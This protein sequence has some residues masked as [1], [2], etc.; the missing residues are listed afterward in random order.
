A[1]G[2]L[3]NAGANRIVDL[4]FDGKPIDRNQKFVV[5]TNNYRAGGGGNFPDINASKI[6][7]EAPDTNRDVIVRY[8]VSEGT[9]NPSA[10]DNWSFAPLP[11]ASAVFETGPR[12]K[13]FIAQVKSLKIEP[14]G[15]GE[16][17]FAKYRILL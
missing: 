8:I 13:D 10:D 4:S 2:G 9:I 1:K 6:I 5:A 12:A 11:G 7:Y 16:A 17:G 14:A 15:E 3:A